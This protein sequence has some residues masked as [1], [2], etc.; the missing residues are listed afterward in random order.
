MFAII[1]TATPKGGALEMTEIDKDLQILA[2]AYAPEEQDRLED[3][4][5][6]HDGAIT[7]AEAIELMEREG[8]APAPPEGAS[9]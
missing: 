2:F 7:V 3:F 8:E 5:R 1:R 9:I 6:Q 4:V